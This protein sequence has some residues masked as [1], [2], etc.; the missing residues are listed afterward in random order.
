[1][2]ELL[3]VIAIIGMLIAL[4]LPAVQAAREAARRMQ[5]VNNMRQIGIGVHNFHDAHGGL[6]PLAITVFKGS[7]LNY[8]YPFVEKEG[9][10]DIL[11]SPG[12][13]DAVYFNGSA[14]VPVDDAHKR[15]GLLCLPNIAPP[16][17][18]ADGAADHSCNRQFFQTLSDEI[19]QQFGSVNIYRCP[20]HGG[21]GL[22]PGVI[23]GGGGFNGDYFSGPLTDYG[24]ILCHPVYSAAELESNATDPY[25]YNISDIL[26]Q[27]KK[28]GSVV[29][30]YN[31]PFRSAIVTWTD[32]N[33]VGGDEYNNHHKVNSWSPRDTMSWLSDGTS[34][35]FICGEV[36]IPALAEPKHREKVNVAAGSSEWLAIERR[37]SW[38]GTYMY[39]STSTNPGKYLHAARV[40]GP[41]S[42]LAKNPN[43]PN[44]LDS[45]EPSGLKH[46]QNLSNPVYGWH[47]G[48]RHPGTVN[49]LLG[50]GSVHQFS[51][52]TPGTILWRLAQTNDGMP[53]NLP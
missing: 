23:D 31:C 44:V 33:Y 5:C 20:S 36:F 6:P 41:D 21:P 39:F 17:P 3:V 51:T 7:W 24:G 14:F 11:T 29:V 8:I 25:I 49:F 43:D 38:N 35:Q 15:K 42:I 26:Y 37:G 52:E 4:L 32:A 53:V 10:W 1:L 40:I 46:I 34:N 30:Q 48:S 27:Y 45:T 2:V 18:P 50:D 12:P 19:R 13:V 16:F 22:C 28:R 47:F 9:L